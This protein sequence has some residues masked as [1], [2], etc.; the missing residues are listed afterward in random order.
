MTQPLLERELA[1]PGLPHPGRVCVAQRVRCDPGR[2]KAGA[3]AGTREQASQLSQQL[4]ERGADVLE[5]PT[6]KITAPDNHMLLA[7]ALVELNAYDLLC[8]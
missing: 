1:H 4:S 7:E 2:A 6:I 3:L 5:I 8:I